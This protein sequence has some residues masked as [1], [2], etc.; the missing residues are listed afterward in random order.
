VWTTPAAALAAQARG[1]VELLPPTWVSLHELS[2]HDDVAAALAAV[3]ARP[4]ERYLTRMVHLGGGVLVSLWYP[5]AAYPASVTDDPG[6][7]DTP[8]ARHR[9]YMDPAGWRYERSG[10]DHELG[11]HA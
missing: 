5:D 6:P 9:L 8:G 11:E 7:L 2:G 4:T 10:V 3:A 1:E